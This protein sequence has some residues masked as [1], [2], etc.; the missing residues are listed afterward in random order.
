MTGN[1]LNSETL[2]D[3]SHINYEDQISFVSN[4]PVWN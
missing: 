4:Q 2:S 1:N 3:W